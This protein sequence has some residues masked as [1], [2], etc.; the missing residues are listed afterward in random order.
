V[1]RRET[2]K[3]VRDIARP[4][5][6]EMGMS[7]V[8]VKFAKEG[9]EWLLRLII[10][11]GEGVGLADCEAVSLRISPLL[12]E[13]D[14]MQAPYNLEVSS[15]GLERVLKSDEEYAIF[16][17]RRI[18]V[19]TYTPFGEYGREIRGTLLGLAEAE[20]SLGPQP[21]TKV[22]KVCTGPGQE[23]AIPVSMVA[24]ARLDEVD[25]PGKGKGRGGRR[26]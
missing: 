20:S 17:G 8:E 21:A 18:A 23:A 3:A 22:V 10:F 12:D 19:S 9:P 24:S 15:P 5:I 26:K 6:E 7:L 25:L 13:I 2:E 11:K 4:V 1:G 16:A 14:L